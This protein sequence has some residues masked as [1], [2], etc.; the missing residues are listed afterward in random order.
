MKTFKINSTVPKVNLALC[1]Y[2]QNWMGEFSV[3][4]I[5][6]PRSGCVG[7]PKKKRL[8]EELIIDNTIISHG[9]KL[10]RDET[11][12]ELSF[13]EDN[14]IISQTYNDTVLLIIKQTHPLSLRDCRNNTSFYSQEQLS[15]MKTNSSIKYIF[16]RLQ[17]IS[18]NH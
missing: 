6:E 15:T 7:I 16:E 5:T 8:E 9:E 17:Q 13:V 3:L 2:R 10:L 4:C 12:M 18:F 14:V 11:G 1:L